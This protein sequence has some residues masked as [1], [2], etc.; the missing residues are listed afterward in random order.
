M[1]GIIAQAAALPDCTATSR[2]KEPGQ[3]SQC[4]HQCWCAQATSTGSN[5]LHHA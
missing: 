1:T 5:D 2:T 3:Q 4:M